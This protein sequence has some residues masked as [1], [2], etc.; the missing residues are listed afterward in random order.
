VEFEELVKLYR[1]L[2]RPRKRLGYMRKKGVIALL[3]PAE[4][5][6]GE[7]EGKAEQGGEAR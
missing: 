4:G 3:V 7:G 6:G 5:H 2:K 1:S